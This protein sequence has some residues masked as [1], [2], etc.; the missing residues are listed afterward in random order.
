M[1]FLELSLKLKGFPF[2]EAEAEL[3]KIQDLS[4]EEFRTWHNNKRWEIV[5]YHFDNNEFYKNKIGA[6]LPSEWKDL[7]VLVKSDFQK[8]DKKLISDTFEQKDLYTGYT[9]GSSGH[10]FNY[11]KDKFAHAMTWALIKDRY[12]N[13]GLTLESKQARFYG[14]PFER[15]SYMIEK[16]KDLLSNRVRFPV[17]D[18]SDEMLETFLEKFRTTKFD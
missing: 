17:F 12:R 11:A 8:S 3:K 10:P 4:A 5:N 7:P 15:I 6:K 9:S 16:T 13:F 14:I 18:L 1:S 2:S